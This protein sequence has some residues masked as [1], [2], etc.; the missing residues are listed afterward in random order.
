MERDPRAYLWDVREAADAILQFVAGLDEAAYAAAP[1]VHSAVERKFE[2]IGE[3]LSQLSKI[4]PELARHVPHVA[5]IVAFR[6]LLIHGYAMVDHARV[7]RIVEQSLP[8]LRA[9]VAS[10]LE[11]VGPPGSP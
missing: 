7:W 2:V 11:R 9:A 5:H 3:A 6:N 1:L 10:L 4:D 8:E